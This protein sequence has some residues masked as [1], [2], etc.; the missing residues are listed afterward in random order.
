MYPLLITG[1]IK[2]SS[3]VPRLTV[4]NEEI[5]RKQYESTILW[6]IEE[7]EIKDIV[8]CDNSNNSLCE[9]LYLLANKHNKNLEML[10]FQGDIQ[11]IEKYGKGYG[12]GEIIE[13]VL[14]KS[15]IIRRNSGFIKITGR[16][17]INNID[18]LCKDIKAG[19]FYYFTSATTVKHRNPMVET[20]FYVIDKNIYDSLFKDAY[21]MV[22]DNNGIYLEK[23]F[24]D[25]IISKKS[26][27]AKFNCYP[28]FVGVSG[29]N[30]NSYK[31]S[32]HKLFVK[33]ICSFFGFYIYK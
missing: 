23:V 7:T 4:D 24:R 3:K 20:R 19:R 10:S 28:D 30:G 2:P 11:S 9:D 25:I 32:K 29:S 6:A 22:D 17:K 18:V 8:F 5:R 15:E 1:C 31:I 33:S 12:E 27:G 16:L 21:K 13:Y 14:N 26:I